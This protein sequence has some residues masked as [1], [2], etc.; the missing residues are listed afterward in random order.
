MRRALITLEGMGLLN[1]KPGRGTLVADP[2]P[3]LREAEA[4]QVL[5]GGAPADVRG[6]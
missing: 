1:R 4:G 2:P 5:A 3:R 6:A